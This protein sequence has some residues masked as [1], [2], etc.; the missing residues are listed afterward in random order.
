MR[1]FAASKD[2]TKVPL[3]ILRK[4]GTRLDGNNPTLLYGYGGYGINLTACASMR[5]A[6]SGLMPAVFTSLPT[7]A[8]AANTARRG[9]RP[10]T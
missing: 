4:K 2:G 7:C 9:T 3:N 6:A 8:A 5:R 1:E 10:G